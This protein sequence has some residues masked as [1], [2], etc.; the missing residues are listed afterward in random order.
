MWYASGSSA[1]LRWQV[2]KSSAS[3]A[4]SKP[5]SSDARTRTA[6][7]SDMKVPST[8]SV[9]R[10]MIPGACAAIFGFLD[11]IFNEVEAGDRL[12][13]SRGGEG[14]LGT[15][16]AKRCPVVQDRLFFSRAR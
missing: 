9:L 7:R 10:R 13:A 1:A 2:G 12:A 11:A 6:S 3:K 8:L 14:K 15:R 16:S 4:R 5:R